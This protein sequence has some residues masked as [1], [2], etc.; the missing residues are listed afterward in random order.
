[1][2]T[3][4]TR[5]LVAVAAL[6]ALGLAGAGP[7]GVA[8][9]R[10]S[11]PAPP[12]PVTAYVVN[13]NADTVTPIKTA[14]NTAGPAIAVQIAPWFIAITPDGKTAYAVNT[15]SGTA[16]PI[17]TAS[18]KPGP[19]IPV[20]GYGTSLGGIALIANRSAAYLSHTR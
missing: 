2:R 10:A 18:N 4:G 8:A 16:T 14:T 17:R 7:V 12:G 15:Y 5:A 6:A 20:W 11:E 9:A 3:L 1:M 19:P 13:S